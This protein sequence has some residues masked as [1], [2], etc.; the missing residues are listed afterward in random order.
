MNWRCAALRRAASNVGRSLSRR[1]RGRNKYASGRLEIYCGSTKS[2]WTL[3]NCSSATTC[4]P[5]TGRVRSG[6]VA[7]VC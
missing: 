6:Y 1:F 5:K 2:R 7:R 4:S 3:S